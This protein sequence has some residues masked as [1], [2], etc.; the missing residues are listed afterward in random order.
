MDGVRL[1]GVQPNMSNNPMSKEFE[2]LGSKN[3]YI[4]SALRPIIEA[5]GKDPYENP[6]IAEIIAVQET[7]D[8]Y[9]Q[10]NPSI[11]C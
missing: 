10:N 3:S 5:K 1:K 7:A 8:A 11:N 9:V 4:N 6:L 2:S